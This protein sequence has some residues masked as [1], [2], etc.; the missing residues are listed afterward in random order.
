MAEGT[1]QPTAVPEQPIAENEQVRALL[2]LLKENNSAGYEDFA[3][4][5]ESVTAMENRL[6]MA[7][8]ELEAMREDLQK[9][10][11]HSLKASLQKTSKVLE[12]NIASMQQKLSELKGR[13]VEGCKHI[14]ADFKERGTVALSGITRFLH[15]KPAF[16]AIRQSAEN[17]QQVSNRAMGKIDAFVSEYHEAG[18][19]LKNMRLA[20]MGKEPVQEAKTGGEIARYVK[21]PYR[22]SR[23]CMGTVKKSAERAMDALEKLEQAAERRPS[24]LKAMREQA[25]NTEAAKKQPAPSHDKE[26]R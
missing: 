12:A 19:H 21:A 26:S 20:L 7:V 1:T 4:L 8:G 18:K 14:L 11:N 16:E 2:A 3:K 24:V 22:A 25:A 17:H 6:S 5:I 15:L 10:Q 9:M 13:I 23:A